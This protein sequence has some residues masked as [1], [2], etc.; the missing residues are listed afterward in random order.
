MRAK[1]PYRGNKNNISLQLKL[2][3]GLQKWTDLSRGFFVG[4][5]LEYWCGK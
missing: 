2:I 4:G 5:P 3:L 1:A